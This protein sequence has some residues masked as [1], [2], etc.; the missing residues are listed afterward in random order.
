MKVERLNVLGENETVMPK[1][2]DNSTFIYTKESNALLSKYQ[3]EK[4]GLESAIL[5]DE[6]K[7]FKL[8]EYLPK[9]EFQN[10]DLSSRIEELKNDFS[11]KKNDF[12]NKKT[13]RNFFL[14]IKLFFI[15]SFRK[16]QRSFWMCVIRIQKFRLERNLR[17][18]H[19][20]QSDLVSVKSDISFIYS[21]RQRGLELFKGEWLST[22]EIQTIRE[23]EIGIT[24]NFSSMTPREFELFTAELLKEMGYY[25]VVV[26]PEKGD[27]GT[28]IVAKKDGIT[29]AVQC[30]RFNENNSVG[31][32][33]IQQLLGSMKYY[34]AS[35]AIFVTTSYYT[36]QAMEQTKNASIDLW[37][38]DTLH[39]YVKKYLLK[40]NIPEIF[41]AIDN[42]KQR[43]E[44]KRTEARIRAEEKRE[45]QRDKTICPIC[46]GRKQKTRKMCYRCKEERRRERKREREDS[47]YYPYDWSPPSWDMDWD[48][49]NR[50]FYR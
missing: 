20:H 18:Q 8:K 15:L 5:N 4:S 36:P 25:D 22:T 27:F 40:K 50:R 11:D 38:K 45:R 14:V 21:Q 17:L 30:K 41:N 1:K 39:G 10:R 46:G 34:H 3:S 2:Y 26:T 33:E 12:K 16:V 35:H 19:D 31:N 23:G 49:F 47:G 6:Q 9:R 32:R 48:D 37:D 29:T 13:F 43:D 44:E 42:A 7:I 24:D 28:D